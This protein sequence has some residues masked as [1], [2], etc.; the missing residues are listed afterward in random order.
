MSCDVERLDAEAFKGEAVERYRLRAGAASLECLS[1]GCVIT[2]LDVPGRDGNCANVVLGHSDPQEYM[3]RRREYFGAV[4]GRVANRIARGCFVLDGREHRL[5]TN[6]GA[7]HL[8]GGRRGF[9]RRLWRVAASA[10]GHEASVRLQLTSPDGDEGYPGELEA[11]VVY[12]LTPDHALRIDYEATTAAPTVVNL[13]QHSYFNLAG[14][15]RGDVFEHQIEIAAD[16]ICAVDETLVPTGELRAVEGTVFDLRAPRAIGRALESRDGQL[17]VAGGFDHCFALQGWRARG[18]A[19]R[20]ACTLSEP[21]SGRRLRVETDQ[22]GVQFYSGN[23]LDGTASGTSGVRYA[24]HAGLCLETQHFP[25]TPNRPEFPSIVL[26]PGERY[27][28]TTVLRFDV[29]P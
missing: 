25:D 6:D 28:S 16:E 7:N 15:G 24:K 29:L 11:T 14:E 27:S 8:H 5:A 2:R 26:R 22:P 9:D 19:L 18:R 4:V 17:D 3:A 23:F 20:H 1:L 13:T 10:T 12:T 21:R